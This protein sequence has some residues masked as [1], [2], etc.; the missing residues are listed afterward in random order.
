MTPSML[1]TPSEISNTSW[2]PSN[3]A[4]IG[5]TRIEQVPSAAS[6]LPRPKALVIRQVA[7]TKYL[8]PWYVLEMLT[9]VTTP[10]RTTAITIGE[11]VL[12]GELPGRFSPAGVAEDVRVGGKSCHRAAYVGGCLGQIGRASW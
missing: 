2:A 6:L 12:F 8:R 1:M 7:E 3:Q 9:H 4:T 11:A 5:A 10:I